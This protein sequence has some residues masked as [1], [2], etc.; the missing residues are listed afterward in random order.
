VTSVPVASAIPNRKGFVHS[1]FAAKHQIVDVTGLKPGQEVKCPF[2]G[3]LFR[4][5]ADALTPPAANP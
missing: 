2:S 5:P 1:P 4:I 3:K